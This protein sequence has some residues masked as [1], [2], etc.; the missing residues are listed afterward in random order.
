[1]S[2]EFE[3]K[4]KNYLAKK[5]SF[6][7]EN[8]DTLVNLVKEVIKDINDGVKHKQMTNKV[9]ELEDTIQNER[10]YIDN[11]FMEDEY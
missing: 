8:V 9:L 7:E 3:D 4:E 5:I 2:K 10:D 6:L 11:E 1:M